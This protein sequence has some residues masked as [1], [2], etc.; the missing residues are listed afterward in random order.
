M[1]RFVL[2]F[3]MP[4]VDAESAFREMAKIDF[5]NSL[6]QTSALTDKLQRALSTLAL[7]GVCLQQA[8]QPSKKSQLERQASNFS[9]R[10]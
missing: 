10:R 6:S 3:Y 8:Q 1:G 7:A 4:R 5:D 9:G 2:R